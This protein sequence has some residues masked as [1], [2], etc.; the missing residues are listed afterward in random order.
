MED[1]KVCATTIKQHLDD[2][3]NKKGDKKLNG[4]RCDLYEYVRDCLKYSQY[5]ESAQDQ[6]DIINAQWED[7]KTNNTE[8]TTKIIPLCDVSGSMESDNC[9]PLYNAI[10]LSIRLSEITHPA[11]RNRVLT[12]S[13]NPLWVNLE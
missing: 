4:K 10:G 9:I 3:K 2:V 7:N 11:F 6:L 5:G 8:Q 12:F 1:R 13:N